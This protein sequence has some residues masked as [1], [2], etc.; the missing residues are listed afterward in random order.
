MR[1]Q[2]KK[3]CVQ[4]GFPEGQGAMEVHCKESSLTQTLNPYQASQNLI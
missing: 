3:I 1:T 4:E 2:K